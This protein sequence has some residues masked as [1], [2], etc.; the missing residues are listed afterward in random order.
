M[1]HLTTLLLFLTLFTVTPT[2]AGPRAASPVQGQ[3]EAEISVG[4]VEA[5]RILLENGVAGLQATLANAGAPPITFDQ[6]TQVRSVYDEHIRALNDLLEAN[7]GNR[8]AIEGEIRALGDQL[9]LA[10]IKFLNPAQRA[11]WTGSLSASDMAELN[12]DLPE[13]EA[14]LREY[15]NDLRS[16]ASGTT[17]NLGNNDL[18][19]D[20]FGGGRLP[21][22]DEIQEIRINENAF[23]AQSIGQSR[24]Q[25]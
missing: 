24:G 22:R 13:D 10:A 19:I 17:A 25:T 15:L 1:A 8:E 21:N 14:E 3:A 16:P 20:G 6:E 23:T 5:G 9:L 18:V 12:S 11:A 7:G 2:V 4:R